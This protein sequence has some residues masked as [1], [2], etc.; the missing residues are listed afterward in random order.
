MLH[1]GSSGFQQTGGHRWAIG[2]RL[3]GLTGSM[4]REWLRISGWRRTILDVHIGLGVRVRV[5]I[6]AAAGEGGKLGR[7]WSIVALRWWR[8][9]SVVAAGRR[10]IVATGRWWRRSVVS[11]WWRWR[12]SI[13][14]I[15]RS[16]VSNG[17]VLLGM[18]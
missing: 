14:S 7:W 2:H 16:R 8:R 9:R 11:T 4:L 13:V 6:A 1:S 3:V 5:A 15:R 10:S 12:R 18:H 17:L